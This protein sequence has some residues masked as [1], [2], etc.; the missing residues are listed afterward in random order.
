MGLIVLI[1]AVIL[2]SVL[3]P[4]GFVYS[5]LE[6]FWNRGVKA[7]LKRVNRY[8]YLVAVSIDQLGNVV[9]KE[10]FNDMLITP[11]SQN[12]FGDPD[13]TISSVLGKNKLA[14]TLTKTG[15][16]LD[17]ILGFLDT[18]HSINSIERTAQ[19]ET[20]RQKVL[21]VVKYLVDTFVEIGIG[22]LALHYFIKGVLYVYSIFL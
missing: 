4:I 15:K 17:A 11:N 2:G 8:F 18:N 16:M 12:L 7:S 1:T 21:R 6:S 14:G 5:F 19:P 22:L 9:C 10:L 3:L 13:E 20:K